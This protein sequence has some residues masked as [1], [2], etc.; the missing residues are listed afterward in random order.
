ML[1][2]DTN[3]VINPSNQN[4]PTN[5]FPKNMESQ[6]KRQKGEPDM[7]HLLLPFQS[8]SQPDQ[9]ALSDIT[10]VDQHELQYLTLEQIEIFRKREEFELEKR[11]ELVPEQMD[12]QNCIPE[13]SDFEK[14]INQEFDDAGKIRN[15]ILWPVLPMGF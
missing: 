9:D 6:K 11:R 12:T 1:L 14:A 5:F 10:E 15:P 13:L 2:K 3:T 4:F 8:W 7:L